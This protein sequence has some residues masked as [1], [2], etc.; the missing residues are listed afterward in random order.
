MEIA[1]GS[2]L[3]FRVV[4][5]I[6]CAA[7]LSLGQ[8]SAG[9]SGQVSDH[10]SPIAN[11]IVT[12][13]NHDATRSITTDSTGRFAFEQMAAGNYDLRVTA[14]G[15]AIFERELALRPARHRTWVEVKNLIPAN[16]QTVSVAELGTRLTR[17]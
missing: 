15:F 3:L 11:A 2:K 12:I 14:S 10:G 16:Q 8:G 7:A 13:S 17:R 4:A 6:A 9:V 5:G 1:R